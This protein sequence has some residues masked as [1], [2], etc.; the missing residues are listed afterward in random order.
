MSDRR[1]GGMRA[2]LALVPFAV[3]AMVAV[4]FL[5]PLCLVVQQMARDR[6]LTGA[7]RQAASL[8][9][10]LAITT[11]PDALADAVASTEAGADGRLA[12]HLPA[13][14]VGTPRAAPADVAAARDRGRAFPA[15]LRGGQ[16]LL[17]PV[18]RDGAP[19]AV[20]EVFVPRAELSRGVPEAWLTLAGVAVALGVVAVAMGDRLATR[21]VRSSRRLADAAGRVGAGDLD[22]RVTPDGPRELRAAAT[23]FNTM[24]EQ[25]AG[26][27]AAERET[28]ADLSHRLRTPLTALRLSVDGLVA[29]PGDPRRL[30]RGREALAR[31]EGEIDA[32]IATARRPRPRAA[33]CDA[34]GVARERLEFWSALA[35]DQDRP[36]QLIA[37][38]GPV[39]VPV[40]RA[41]LVA[42]IDA[43]MGNVF[44]HTP[45][46]AGFTVTVHRGRHA[47]GL[48][49][50]DA[51]PGIADEDAALRRGTSGAGS[52]GLGLDIARRLAEATG[53]SLR[54]DRS[55]QLGGARIQMWL[56]TEGP[57][58]PGRR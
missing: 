5:L 39:P 40:A 19:T 30:D 26:L 25:V 50:A 33:G 1:P 22:V 42:A 35:E 12:L 20:I 9:P 51:G 27:L 29:N 7:E 16:V 43:L 8:I 15:E 56:R 54:V 31:L 52:T 57:R 6:A 41:E 11:D 13:A 38:D 18:V 48:L 53:G 10:V 34:A 45:R 4:S 46:G 17:R 14:V 28:A 58:R 2:T 44:R 49:F 21:V 3:T 47:V 55:P 37:P 24:A 32:L 23:A 36:H